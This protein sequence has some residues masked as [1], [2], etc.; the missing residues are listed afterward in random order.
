MSILRIDSKLDK[1]AVA[2]LSAVAFVV[3]IAAYVAI[4][5]VRHAENPDDKLVPTLTEMADGF[6]RTA[7]VPDRKHELRL[8]VDT[9]ASTKRF[10]ISQ[11]FLIPAIVLGLYSLDIYKYHNPRNTKNTVIKVYGSKRFF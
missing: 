6:Y 7:F 8:Y 10:F 5:S 2:L 11:L 3:L 4:S 9:V 1:R